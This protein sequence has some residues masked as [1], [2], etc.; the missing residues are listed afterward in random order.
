MSGSAGAAFNAQDR[1]PDD[2]S[3]GTGQGC[4]VRDGAYVVVRYVGR[5]PE[6]KLRTP[7]LN[8]T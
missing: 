7:G 4:G 1:K 6:G 2:E 3:A 8:T 5:I